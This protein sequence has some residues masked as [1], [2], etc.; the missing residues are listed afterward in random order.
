MSLSN[1]FAMQT[2]GRLPNVLTADGHHTGARRTAAA[3]ERL[4]LR[5]VYH[6][7]SKLMQAAIVRF[8]KLCYETFP[9]SNLLCNV[10]ADYR[11]DIGV[12]WSLRAY[13]TYGLRRTEADA[14]RREMHAR[15]APENADP[16]LFVWLPEFG[17]WY[18][19]LHAYP[20]EADAGAYVHQ[21]PVTWRTLVAHYASR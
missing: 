14:L 3:A 20:T 13:Q 12:P 1:G 5:N 15:C 21:F 10:G 17:R 4:S 19:D 11:I 18:L 7:R 2:V 6:A 8:T 9:G 16:P